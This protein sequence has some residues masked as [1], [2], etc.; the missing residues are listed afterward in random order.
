M[1]CHI[2]EEEDAAR[3]QLIDMGVFKI[4]FGNATKLMKGMVEWLV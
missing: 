2:E 1:V 3:S 4:T